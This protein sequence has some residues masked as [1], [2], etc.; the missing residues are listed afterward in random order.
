MERWTIAWICLD[1]LGVTRSSVMKHVHIFAVRQS[2]TPGT[3]GSGGEV[4]AHGPA[5]SSSSSVD[6]RIR[7]DDPPTGGGSATVWNRIRRL[8]KI[9]TLELNVSCDANARGEYQ[10]ALN[11][12]KVAKC[13]QYR[14]V[15]SRGRRGRSPLQ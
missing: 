3:A 15:D 8:E 2:S 11:H 9:V 6:P 1:C 12:A 10:S 4:T 7:N 13:C 14:G 5:S